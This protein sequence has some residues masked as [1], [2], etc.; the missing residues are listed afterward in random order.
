MLLYDK[1]LERLGADAVRL[2]HRV[3]GY[4]NEADGVTALI[5][6]ADGSTD[7]CAARC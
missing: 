4:R 2:G 5:E 3:T 7:E 1:V 6:H